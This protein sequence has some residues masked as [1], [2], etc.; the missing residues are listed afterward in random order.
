MQTDILEKKM[1]LSYF[2][3]HG[4][5]RTGNLIDWLSPASDLLIRLWVANVFWKAGT[6]KLAS[7]DSTLYLFEY[8]YEV[9]LLPTE[10]AAYL[11]TGVELSMPVLLALGLATRFSALV[12]FV[13]NII[14]V[15]SYPSLNEIGIKDHQYW[16]LLLMVPLFH[17]AGRLSL[18]YLV[19]KFVWRKAVAGDVEKPQSI[20]PM[21]EQA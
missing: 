14:A 13:F 10:L 4:V 20:Q 6:A 11:G 3:R 5:R 7:W 12:L 18:D 1:K 21:A 15:V 9:P 19:K 17:G 16:G 8:E 2:V